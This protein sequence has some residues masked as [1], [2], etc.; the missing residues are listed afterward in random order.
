MVVGMGLV[1]VNEKDNQCPAGLSLLG[2][3]WGAQEH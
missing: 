3:W 2:R 1:V